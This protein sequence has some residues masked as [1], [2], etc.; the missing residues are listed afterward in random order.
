M[1]M[2]IQRYYTI[3]Q[4][5]DELHVSV[6]TI[7]RFCNRGLVPSIKRAK[8]GRRVFTPE[9][10]TWLKT[11]IHLRESGLSTAELKKYVALCRSGKSG[12]LE[13]KAMLETKKRQLWQELED[14]QSNI[15]FIERKIEIF[16]KSLSEGAELPGEYF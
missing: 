8:N 5:C 14:I 7:R 11:L 10:I 9:Q 13:R 6:Y 15:D 12:I 4:A 1:V 3:G 16:D 2:D